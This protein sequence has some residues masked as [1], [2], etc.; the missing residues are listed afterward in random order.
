M[1]VSVE[2]TQGLERRMTVQLPSERVD[3]EVDKRLRDMRGQ[4]R[5]DGFRPGKVPLKVVEKRYGSQVRGEVLSEVL[6]QSYAEALDQES[7]RPAGA[8]AIEPTQT[9]AGKDLEYVATFEIMPD[10]DVQ[11]L[12]KLKV[13]RPVAEIGDADIDKVL[14]NLRKQSAEYKPVKRK[15]KEGDRVTID[16]VGKIDGEDFSGNKGEDTP[17][18][19]GSG[20]M[21]PEFEKAMKGVKP[22]EEK[23]VEYTFPENFPDPEV[24][25][26]T[27]VFS[28]TIKAVDGPVL[29][30]AD[31]AFAETVGIK[32]GGI[33]QLREQIKQGLER[34]RDQVI[35]MRLKRQIMEQLSEANQG[36]ELPRVLVDGEI[37]ALRKQAEEQ[38]RRA[39]Q[40]PTEDQLNNA[41]Y[42]DDARRRVV[43]GLVVNAIIRDNDIKLDQDKVRERLQQ[44]AS[45][46]EQPQQVMQYYMQNRQMMES[47]EVAALEDQ[48]VDWAMER[49]KVEDKTSS[50]EQLMQGGDEAA[51]EE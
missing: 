19:I 22:E 38:L 14:D 8:P 17:V 7:L 5:M 48:V 45:G 16:F 41:E 23:E 1:Q 27:A 12:D 2:T 20:Q 43:L 25:G 29:P 50:F 3:T 21:P 18:T 34:E 36:L 40:E 28:V 24:A 47:L 4:V 10:V 11:G 6:Q 42:E 30:D 35:G 46:Y 31:D 51:S 49:A 37:D 33:A 13:E 26:K 39:G 9:D 44:I 32:E 15:A